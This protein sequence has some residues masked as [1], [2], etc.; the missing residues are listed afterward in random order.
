MADMEKV[1]AAAGNPSVIFVVNCLVLCYV[2]NYE[3]S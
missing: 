2:S 3:L 1:L